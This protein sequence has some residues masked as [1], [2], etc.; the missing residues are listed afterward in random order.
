MEIR[1]FENYHDFYHFIQWNNGELTL[2]PH[3]EV[4]DKKNNLIARLIKK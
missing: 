1:V 2:K 3:F 4:Y